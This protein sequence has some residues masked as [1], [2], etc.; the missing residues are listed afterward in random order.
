MEEIRNLK[1]IRNKDGH[2]TIGYKITLP[3]KWIKSMGLDTQD[4][5]TLIFKDNS[6]ILKNKEDF[7]MENIIKELK[8]ELLNK[9]LTL[10]EMD[11]IAEKITGSTTSVFDAYTDCMDQKSCA[12]YIK[13]DKN[14]VV[15]FKITEENEDKTEIKVI[16]TD[17]WED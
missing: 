14:I 16:V 15:E 12:Y 9:E 1:I 5:A 2:G 13:E 4:Y 8:K 11:N 7:E 17:I 10:C 6:I 3:S